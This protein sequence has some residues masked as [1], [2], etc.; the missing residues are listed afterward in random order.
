M[1]SGNHER[2]NFQQQTTTQTTPERKEWW[3]RH[4][5]VGN[6]DLQFDDDGN[7]SSPALTPGIGTTTATSTDG[8]V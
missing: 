8:S 6:I 5:S 2:Q 1:P 3:D 4:M 7:G